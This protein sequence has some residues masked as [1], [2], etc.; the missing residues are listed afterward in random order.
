MEKIELEIEALIF[1]A[2]TPISVDQ[3]LKCLIEVHGPA[4]VEDDIKNT[5]EKLIK[6]YKKRQS[7]FE[8][9]KV[10]GGYQFLTKSEFQETVAVHLKQESKKRLSRSAI[11][12]LAI[13]AYKQPV[14][15]TEIELIRGVSCDYS[16]RKLLDKE[17][18][19]IVGKSD[20]IGRPM[21]Y[22]TTPTFLEYFGINDLS[23]LPSPK[24]FSEEEKNKI[25]KEI[26]S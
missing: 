18:I 21:L 15:K 9:C 25:G 3:L 17:L 19:E 26:D 1:C 10:G 4:I 22:G 5:I 23:E 24:E 6:T 16:V 11:E 12:T 14:T 8:L 20:A 7:S 13:V 2:K